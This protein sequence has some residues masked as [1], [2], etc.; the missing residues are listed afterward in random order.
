[1]ND[2]NRS[3]FFYNYGLYMAWIVSIAATAGSLYLSEVMHFTPCR[4]CWFQ[5]IFMYPQVILLGMA[6]YRG[7]RRMASYVLPLAIIGG[8]ISAWHYA[9]QK[10]PGLYKMVPC[11]DGVPCNEDYLDWFGV[12]T[13]PLMAL[14]AFILIAGNLWLTNRAYKREE[15]LEAAAE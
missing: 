7:D 13:I 6:A 1:M 2:D 4:W 15:A 9:E 14:V 5:R 3:S 10:V 12:I 11:T 8:C